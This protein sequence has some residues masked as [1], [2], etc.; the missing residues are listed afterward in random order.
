MA[1]V[2]FLKAILVRVTAAL[3]F[4]AISSLSFSDITSYG[5]YKRRLRRRLSEMPFLYQEIKLSSD[6]DYVELKL[7]TK[8]DDKYS[9]KKGSSSG[10]G[11]IKFQEYKKAI[12]FGFGGYGKSTLFRNQ[13]LRSIEWKG[14]KKFLFGEK[15][16]PVFVAL[17]TVKI[18]QEHPILDAIQSS[19]PYLKGGAGVRRLVHAS[20]RGTLRVY[21]DGYDEMPYIGGFDQIKKELEIILGEGGEGSRYGLRKTSDLGQRDLIAKRPREYNALRQARV[22]LSTRKEF[23]DFYPL[24]HDRDVQHWVVLGIGDRRAEL[25][26]KVF[27]KFRGKGNAA[28]PMNLDAEF[29]LQEMT[30]RGGEE[31]VK[32]SHSPLFLTVMCVVYIAQKSAGKDLEVFSYGARQLIS[33]FIDLLIKGLDE[34]KSREIT[35]SSSSEAMRQRRSLFPEEKRE[36]LRYLAFRYYAESLSIFSEEDL[37]EKARKYVT[38][39]SCSKNSDEIIR[40]LKSVDP[41]AN[42]VKQIISSGLL[43]VVDKRESQRLFDFPHKRFRETLAVEYF[44]DDERVREI[45]RMAGN[46]AYFEII[47]SFVSQAERSGEVLRAIAEKARSGEGDGLGSLIGEILTAVSPKKAKIF[48]SDLLSGAE[49]KKIC[50]LPLSIL[51]FMPPYDYTP[52]IIISR[53]ERELISGDADGVIFW[54]V[55]AYRVDPV[56]SVETVKKLNPVTVGIHRYAALYLTVQN[57]LFDEVGLATFEGLMKIASKNDL[58]RQFLVAIYDAHYSRLDAEKKL[59]FDSAVSNV[60]D[61]ELSIFYDFLSLHYSG[62]LVPK[63]FRSEIESIKYFWRFR[64]IWFD[65]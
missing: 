59:L 35:Y 37:N 23:F 58:E 57:S 36:F 19:D 28:K 2:E 43:V 42:I 48:L 34:Y 29:F 45:I 20:R 40:G 15:I 10:F 61:N 17:K 3:S 60:R 41:T 22:Y 30:I 21:L 65:R 38:N 26:E 18:G 27:E 11:E 5:R 4:R 46:S 8:S 53:F 63:A 51:D 56:K 24:D 64:K 25:V 1:I 16:L 55:I 50:A 52:D 31:I 7:I 32:M 9:F 49:A 33:T 47:T 44:D 6:S 13:V 62:N 14:L 54:S 39:Y 12:V